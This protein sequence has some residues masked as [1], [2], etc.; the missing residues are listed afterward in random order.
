MKKRTTEK[1]HSSVQKP[2]V[3]KLLADLIRRW[4]SSFEDE[5]EYFSFEDEDYEWRRRYGYLHQ[6]IYSN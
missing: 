5:G 4:M 2:G 3:G 6:D 1:V